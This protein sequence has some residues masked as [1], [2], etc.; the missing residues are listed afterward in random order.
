MI[1]YALVTL[2]VVCALLCAGLIFGW[3]FWIFDNREW[4][5]H[6][7]AWLAWAVA[8]FAASVHPL[9]DHADDALN[10]RRKP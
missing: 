10:R 9:A 2:A 7:T 3:G 5:Q 4:R 8:F 6:S 1:R